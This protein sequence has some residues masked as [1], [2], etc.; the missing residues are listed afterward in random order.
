T[1][2]WVPG[3]CDVLGNEAADQEVKCAITQGSSL[4]KDLPPLLCTTLPFSK[5]ALWAAFKKKIRAAA[6]AYWQLS[7]CHPRVSHNIPA[8][9]SPFN[10]TLL[11]H[12]IMQL[13]TGHISLNK[14]LHHIEKV[15]LPHCTKC[16]SASPES[17]NHFLL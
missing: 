12:L 17:V 13:I 14:Y 7:P 15:A 11:L 6:V 5:S 16:N 4:C 3:H 8:K 1:L 10:S 2:R 9:L